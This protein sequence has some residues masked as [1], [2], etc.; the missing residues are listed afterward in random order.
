M[1]SVVTY[2]LCVIVYSCL[3]CAIVYFISA[4]QTA[5]WLLREVIRDEDRD[6]VQA[7]MRRDLVAGCLSLG[8]FAV[9][10]LYR[11]M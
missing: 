8:M 2:T 10:A 1:S 3:G 5:L 7:S 4:M 9:I 6:E 11:F